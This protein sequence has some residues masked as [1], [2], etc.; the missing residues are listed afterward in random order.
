MC[1]IGI[2]ECGGRCVVVVVCG[3]VGYWVGVEFVLGIDGVCV[4]D[5]SC[6][7]WLR[8][9]GIGRSGMAGWAWQV[10][11]WQV[12]HGRLGRGR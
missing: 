11:A 4:A 10:G 12:G 1:G 9:V 8:S 6:K 2:E 5:W 7:V 3:L